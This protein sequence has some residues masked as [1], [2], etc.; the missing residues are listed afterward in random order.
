MSDEKD[1]SAKSAA[2]T[3][4]SWFYEEDVNTGRPSGSE[5]QT[6]EREKASHCVTLMM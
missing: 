2:Q 3:K 6:F 5:E 4:A 1:V